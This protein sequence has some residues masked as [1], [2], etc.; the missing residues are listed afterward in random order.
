MDVSVGRFDK[1]ASHCN[2]RGLLISVQ[3]WHAHPRSRDGVETLLGFEDRLGRLVEGAVARVPVSRP[4]D[5][6]AR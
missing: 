1:H 6:P 4:D 3:I 5:G 2:I